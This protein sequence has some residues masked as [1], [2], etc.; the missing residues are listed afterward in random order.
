[1]FENFSWYKLLPNKYLD[2][3]EENLNEFYRTMFER[4]MIWHKRFIEKMP[5]EQWTKDLIL[6]NNKFTNVYRELDRNSQWLIKNVIFKEKN[7]IYNMIWKIMLFRHFNEPKTFDI[8]YGGIPNYEEYD[9]EKFFKR[10]VKIRA[11]G[12]NPFTTAYLVGGGIKTGISRDEYFCKQVIPELHKCIPIIYEWMQECEMPELFVKNLCTIRGVGKFIAHEFYQDFTYI[13]IYAG[14]EWFLWTQND[15]INVGP[16]ASIGIRLIFPSL[17]NQKEG[18]YILRDIAESKL[19]EFGNFPYLKWDIISSKYVSS[20]E[21]NISLHQIEMWLC[22]YQK[23]WK[24]VM[25]VGKQRSKF[26]PYS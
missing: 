13:K 17:K 19:N 15:F 14:Q 20:N 16:G 23:Y 25:G 2:V 18:I 26:I 5:Q 7:D 4:Q 24:M 6:K 22:E 21:C 11:I 10:I 12:I 3:H 9:E 1:M 8:E